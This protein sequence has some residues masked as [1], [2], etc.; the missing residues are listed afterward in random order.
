[1]PLPFRDNLAACAALGAYGRMQTAWALMG[2]T[3]DYE[4]AFR[5]APGFGGVLDNALRI[6]GRA[7]DPAPVSAL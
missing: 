6:Q 4:I 1:M 5:A 2:N 3:H 7:D